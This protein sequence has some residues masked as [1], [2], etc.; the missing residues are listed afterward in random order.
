ME[1]VP[2]RTEALVIGDERMCRGQ[3]NEQQR[4]YVVFNERNKQATI[5]L[6]DV[7]VTEQGATRMLDAAACESEILMLGDPERHG[8]RRAREEM[9][10][11]PT[12]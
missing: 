7:G 3:V 12:G 6:M 1:T 5:R 9:R 4:G 2:S 10:C 11:V 8:G